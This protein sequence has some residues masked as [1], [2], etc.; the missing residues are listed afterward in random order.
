VELPTSPPWF[1]SSDRLPL[2][3]S[4]GSNDNSYGVSLPYSPPESWSGS[5]TI[6]QLITSSHL[7]AKVV[8]IH[9]EAATVAMTTLDHLA[10]REVQEMIATE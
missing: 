4:Y 8:A 9:M 7:E 1:L 5:V 10:A 6:Q 3:N 2:Q